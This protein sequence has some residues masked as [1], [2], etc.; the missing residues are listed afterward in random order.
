MPVVVTGHEGWQDSLRELTRG[1]G[2]PAITDAH[3]GEFV[4]E[5]LPF[6]ADADT[7]VV[8]GGT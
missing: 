8:W 1:R 6:L 2:V 3:G 5:I 4:S 7:L